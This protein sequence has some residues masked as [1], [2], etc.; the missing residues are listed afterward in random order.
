MLA[1]VFRAGT[2][3]KLKEARALITESGYP[4]S[5]QVSTEEGSSR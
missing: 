2:L 3:D 4:I 5:L 1:V